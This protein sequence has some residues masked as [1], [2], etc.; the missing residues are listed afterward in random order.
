MILTRFAQFE[1]VTIGRLDY[2]GQEFF[3]VERPWKDNK[4]N[5]SSIPDGTY[6]M[7]RV[8]SPKFGE[9]MWEIME[10][11]GRTHILIHVANTADNVLGCIG[12]GNTVY[13]TL[14]GVG[15]SRNAINKFYDL[16]SGLEEEEIT[17]I[18]GAL[19]GG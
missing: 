2:A 13:S 7:G 8:N 11:P 19:H 10:V 17:I 15:S 18:T 6:K 9:D 1:D 3:T 12:L 5:I 16:T 14:R 4:P